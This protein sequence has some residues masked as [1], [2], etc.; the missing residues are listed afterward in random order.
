M[1]REQL[2]ETI[3]HAIQQLGFSRIPTPAI[4]DVFGANQ[5]ASFT[6]HDELKSF[7]ESHGWDLQQEGE[8]F[9]VFYPQGS[10]PPKIS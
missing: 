1:T 9:T 4:L 3:T 7:A 10:E 2:A 6:L 8:N 5:Q